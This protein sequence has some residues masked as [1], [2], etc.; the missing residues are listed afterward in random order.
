MKLTIP[1]L[2][3]ASVL[4]LAAA[5][6]AQ[7]TGVSHPELLND[8]ITT[9][10]PAPAYTP[11][12]VTPIPAASTDHYVPPSHA[13]V[14]PV[15]QAPAPILHPRT[16]P[17]VAAAVSQVRTPDVDPN[18]PNSGV[19]ISVPAAPGELP[20][21]TLLRVSLDTTLS[22]ET[23][24]RG[25]PFTGHIM[26]DV[27]RD[28]QVLIP[29]GSLL[30]G[31][32][33][34]ARSSHHFG[35]GPMLLLQPDTVSLPDGSTRLLDAQ[36]I[37][38]GTNDDVQRDSHV[39]GEGEVVSNSHF[40]GHLTALSLTTGSAAVAGAMMGGG[41]GAVVGGLVGAGAGAILW[42]RQGHEQTLPSGT[43]LV[44]QLNA[45]LRV[46]TPAMT[47]TR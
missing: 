40:K 18:D 2:A 6:P 32:V 14:A 34:E 45:P 22:T 7:T 9:A 17:A 47:A 1:S 43:V 8:N 33:A 41:V 23:A 29:A 44:L 31:R 36:L 19:V 39:S 16:D 4:T 38:F 20:T 5:A 46:S 12:P 37:D 15:Q 27:M 28:G 21:G 10:Q 24:H 25:T 35:S 13:A 11:A 3:A 42:A 26:R 30:R